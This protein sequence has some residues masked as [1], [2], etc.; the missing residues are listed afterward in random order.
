MTRLLQSGALR[1]AL[2]YSVVCLLAVAPVAEAGGKRPNPCLDRAKRAKLLCPDL[3]MAKPFGL[4]LDPFARPGRIV[5]RAGNSIDSMGRGPAELVGVRSGRYRM[6][7]SQR[8]HRRAGGRIAI[9]T[10]ARLLFKY[11]PGQ[12]RYWKFQ[13]AARFDLWR[14][15]RRG[16]RTR[17]LR[18]GPKISYCLR[19]LERT[20]PRLRGSP[21]RRVYPACDTSFQTRRV[22]LGTSVGWSDIYPASYPEQF[23]DVTGLRGCFDY[24]H[25]ADP[26]D[27]I[28]ESNERNNRAV[29]RIRLPFRPGPQRCPR[30]RNARRP[31]EREAPPKQEQPAEQPEAPADYD[32]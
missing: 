17:R 25:T 7:A 5:L 21:A 19:D 23:L 6:R 27:G 14:V 11:I 10:G 22:R 18:R 3:V 30:R 24:V 20:H 12:T 15:N 28:Y 29:V 9:D 16:V 8:I 4:A 1:R 2:A 13:F 26:R 31:R 32:Y